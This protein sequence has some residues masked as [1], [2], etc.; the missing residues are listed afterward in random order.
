M[1]QIKAQFDELFDRF[2]LLVSPTLAVS[3]F[4]VGEPPKMIAGE[5]THWFWG[6]LPFT[7]PINLIGHPAASIPCG[8]DS[9]GLPIGL[10]IIGRKGDESAVIAASAALE[11]EKPWVDHRPKVS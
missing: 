5:D 9:K 1:D 3:A 6:Y 8:F 10:Q 11:M 4:P 2:D 7:F